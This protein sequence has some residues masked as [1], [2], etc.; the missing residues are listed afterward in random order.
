MKRVVLSMALLCGACGVQQ[1]VFNLRVRDLDRCN[2]ELA[3]TQGDLTATRANADQLASDSSDLRDRLNTIEGDRSR[4]SK[5]LSSQSSNLELFKNAATLAQRRVDLYEDIMHKLQPLVDKKL[6][7]IDTTKGRLLIRI[8]EASLFESGKTDLRNESQG[9]LHELASVM[10]Q[11]N[12]DFLVAAHSDNQP[13]APKGSV[14]RSAWEMTVARSVA[15]VRFFQGEGVDPRRLGAAGYSEFS[16][17]APNADDGSKQ[18]NRRIELIVMPAQDEL[19]PLPP[20]L[21]LRKAEQTVIPKVPAVVEPRTP[22]T[23]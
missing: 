5:T 13:V 14:Y 15:V 1:E 9:L 19:L 11:V 17:L 20:A 12:R 8:A 18:K 7:E 6:L 21:E 4:L 3:R 2:A 16:Y 23:K 10:K 22:A